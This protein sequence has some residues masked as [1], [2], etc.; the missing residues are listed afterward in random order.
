MGAPQLANSVAPRLAA[1]SSAGPKAS[2]GTPQ[3]QNQAPNSARALDGGATSNDRSASSAQ[4]I[5][6]GDGMTRSDSATY[7]SP[8]SQQA[9]VSASPSQGQPLRPQR[10]RATT[11][12]PFAM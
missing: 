5:A 1:S 4:P 6:T 12:D 3:P 2:P 7:G 10:V 11:D 9:S 8:A